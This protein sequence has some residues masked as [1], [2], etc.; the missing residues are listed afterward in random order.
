MERKINQDMTAE[1]DVDE[2]APDRVRISIHKPTV[3]E[4][5]MSMTV[6][7]AAL[8]AF[9][10]GDLTLELVLSDG[11]P[12]VIVAHGDASAAVETQIHQSEPFD[13]SG[14]LDGYLR[15]KRY[16]PEDGPAASLERLAETLETSLSQT[17]SA[18]TEI[19]R[20]QGT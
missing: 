19:S 7:R 17:Q 16:E 4:P 5:K 11:G 13:L 10:I 15:E 3:G 18:L 2:D 8:E 14:L 12:I 9:V 20:T 1:L 6:P